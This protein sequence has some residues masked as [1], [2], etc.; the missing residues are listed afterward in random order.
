MVRASHGARPGHFGRYP[1]LK[2]LTTAGL[3]LASL[4]AIA[5]TSS[6]PTP[7]EAGGGGPLCGWRRHSIIGLGVLGALSH[8]NEPPPPRYYYRSS[9][10]PGP[11]ECGWRDRRCSR[12]AGATRS[13]AA[14]AGRVGARPI[15]I[16]ERLRCSHGIEAGEGECF[17]PFVV[18]APTCC[19][20]RAPNAAQW[21]PHSTR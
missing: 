21:L 8:A 3:A 17:R 13:A 5:M 14:A 16:D 9:C 20:R 4:S 18:S 11:E 6:L 1:M 15:A 12:T 10:H 7:A 19:V 2:K